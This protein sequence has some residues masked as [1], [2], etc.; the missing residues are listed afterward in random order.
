MKIKFIGTGSGKTS[1]LR[2]HS[3]FIISENNKNI[4]ADC[5]DGISR[6]LLLQ[7]VDFLSIDSIIISHLHPD[8]YA[9]LPLLLSQ[10]K[11]YGRTNVLKIFIHK[12]SELFIKSIITQSYLFEE[13][14]GFKISYHPFNHDEEFLI[15]N[16][17][18]CIAKQNS[19]VDKYV[20]F[21]VEN[22][23]SLMSS[24]FLIRTDDISLV[25]SGDLGSKNDL[26][27]FGS[28]QYEYLICEIMHIG[29]NDLLPL[30]HSDSIKK[31][32]LT[33]IDDEDEQSIQD[34]VKALPPQSKN[35]VTI[36]YDGFTTSL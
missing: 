5:G 2:A 18:H 15:D 28:D 36:A 10:M 32:Y 11:M 4:L 29:F 9:G 19:H 24:S 7:D 16:I 26:T 33:H 27:L 30:I 22:N 3:S 6:A 21:D 13:K 34:S 31:M 23:L 20:K 14:L 8:H 17:F 12:S 25:Y 35:K 1:L